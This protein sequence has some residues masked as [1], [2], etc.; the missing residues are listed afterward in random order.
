LPAPE[1]D[2]NLTLRMYWPKDE[3][4]SIND[5]SWIPPGAKRVAQ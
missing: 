1:G 5:G 3:P 2:F 4:I